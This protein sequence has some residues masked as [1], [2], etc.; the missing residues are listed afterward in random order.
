MRN[1]FADSLTARRFTY[2]VE[3]VASASRTEADVLDAARGLSTIA[4]L[5]AVSITSYAGGK[6]GQ[7]PVHLAAAVRSLGLVPNV[8]LTC[9]SESRVELDDTLATLDQLAIHNV[10]ALTGDFPKAP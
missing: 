3:L 1:A 5:T 7:D 6:A 2:V 8:H 4:Q 9:V 10:F